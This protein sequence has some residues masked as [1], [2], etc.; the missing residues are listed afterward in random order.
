MFR[1]CGKGSSVPNAAHKVNI[2][3][4]GEFTLGAEGN[5]DLFGKRCAVVH[6]SAGVTADGMVDFK[7]PF[8]IQVLPVFANKLGSWM[9]LSV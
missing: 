2:F 9:F 4:S 5:L 1:C 7:F 6:E 8:T 3:Y